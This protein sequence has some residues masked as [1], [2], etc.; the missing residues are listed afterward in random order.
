MF[1]VVKCQNVV[2][3]KTVLLAQRM[4]KM[5]WTS[6]SEKQKRKQI[7][8]LIVSSHNHM[9]DIHDVKQ[10]R[11][12]KQATC[13]ALYD[14]SLSNKRGKEILADILKNL[15]KDLMWAWS[16]KFGSLSRFFTLKILSF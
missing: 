16:R 7:Q 2:T 8:Q 14:T 15:Y 5:H 3:V 6:S 13:T 12:K 9:R 4:V 10:G 11:K 1:N